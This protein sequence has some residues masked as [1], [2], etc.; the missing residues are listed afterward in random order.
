MSYADALN[1]NPLIERGIDPHVLNISV[2][3][4]K[5]KVAYQAETEYYV[6]LDGKETTHSVKLLFDPFTEYGIDIRLQVPTDELEHYDEGEVITSLDKTMALQSYLQAERLY[7]R[8]SIRYVGQENGMEKIFFRLDSDTIPREIGQYKTFEGYAY[9]KDGEL[10]MIE[11]SNTEPYRDYGIE[12]E[13]YTKQNY[14]SKVKGYNAYLPQKEVVIISGT[15]DGKSY[16]AESTTYV[17]NYWDKEKNPIILENSIKDPFPSN[18]NKEYETF[19]VKLDRILPLLGQATRKEGY[20][21]PKAFGISLITMMQQTRFYMTSFEVDGQDLSRYFDKSSKYENTTMV[22]M[23][24]FDT[25]ILPFLNVG[26]MVGGTDTS[27]TVTLDTATINSTL[28]GLVS[29]KS[30]TLTPFNTKSMLYG[31]GTTLA[32][33]VGDFFGTINLQYMSSYTKSADVKTQ[34]IV[35]TPMFGY[36]FKDYGVRVMGGGMYEDL[37][38]SLDF[39]L[40]EA[41]KPALKGTVGLGANKWA[42]TFGVNYDFTRHWTS[43]IVMAYGEDFQNLNFVVTYRW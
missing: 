6:K 33:G 2:T 21:L 28:G 12:V 32:G 20:D 40:T 11:V 17:L 16:K 3:P 5:Q 15:K 7:D 9:I 18:E 1:I 13:H 8:N 39:D 35:V 4:F 19:Y 37:K 29:D 42:A 26:V 27:T 38:E 31:F 43:N 14:F 23:V 22:S 10:Y 36:Y 25:W 24:Q 34:I 30:V 41:G